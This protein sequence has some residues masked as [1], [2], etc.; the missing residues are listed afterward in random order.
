MFKKDECKQFKIDSHDSYSDGEDISPYNNPNEK[1]SGFGSAFIDPEYR[2]YLEKQKTPREN[3][4]SNTWTNKANTFF[5]SKK[6]TG[7]DDDSKPMTNTKDKKK[8]SGNRSNS[9]DEFND[10][11]NC[12]GGSDKNIKKKESKPMVLG[13]QKNQSSKYSKI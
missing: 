1:N 2:N 3:S 10:F 9:D 6:T 13:S 8:D 7:N 4:D 12:F 11:E 5:N